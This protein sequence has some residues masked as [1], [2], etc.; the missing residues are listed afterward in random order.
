[1]SNIKELE[2]ICKKLNIR[3][4][5]ETLTLEDLDT[6]KKIAENNGT[7]PMKL[8]DFGLVQRTAIPPISKSDEVQFIVDM[9]IF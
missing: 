1:M 7:N 9:E 8:I 5:S 2:K 6:A 4:R 3:P